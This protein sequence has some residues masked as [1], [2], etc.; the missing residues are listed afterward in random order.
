MK[1]IRKWLK[2]GLSKEDYKRAKK[3]ENESW[4]EKA[5]CFEDALKGAFA[6]VDACE[7]GFYWIEIY[8]NGGSIQTDP[9]AQLQADKEELLKALKYANRMLKNSKDAMYDENYIESLIQKHK[10]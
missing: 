10:K 7:G 3:Y 9:T 2:E 5:Y 8:N 1:T 6:W 4:K